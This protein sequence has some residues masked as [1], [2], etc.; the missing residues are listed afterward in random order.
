MPLFSR[1]TPPKPEWLFLGL[2]NPGKQYENTRHNIGFL[3]IQTLSRGC[4]IPLDKKQR[5]AVWGLG[6]LSGENKHVLIALGK[7][8]TFMNRSGLGA[9]A[10]L[11]LFEIPV[12]RLVVIYDDMD[13]ELGRVRVKPKGGPGSHN[14]MASVIEALGTE[15]F[16]RVRIGIGSPKGS[17][18]E[19]VLSAFLPEEMPII[20]VSIQRAS[21]ACQLIALHG[22]DFAMNRINSSQTD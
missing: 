10:L 4:G 5:H 21:L 20:D 7:P 17:G 19:Y 12:Q 11:S 14:G 8:L 13:L 3:V 22:V 15:D 18:V 6:T 16:P 9:K 2:G 1:R